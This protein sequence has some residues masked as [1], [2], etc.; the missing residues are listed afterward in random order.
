MKIL[1]AEC[2][3]EIGKYFKTNKNYIKFIEKETGEPWTTASVNIPDIH[4]GD[5]DVIL[6]I[7]SENSGIMQDL[8]DNDIIEEPHSYIQSQMV[9][10]PVARIKEKW[11]RKRKV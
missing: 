4:I 6:K 11:L 7:Y 3:I 5:E 9:Q 10:F 8:L 1:G 2:D